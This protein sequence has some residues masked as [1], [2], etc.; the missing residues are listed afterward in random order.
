MYNNIE[1]YLGFS[2]RPSMGEVQ[3]PISLAVEMINKLPEEVFISNKTTFLDPCFGSGT[4]LK[5]I[6]KKLREYGH[7]DE[8]I[9]SRLFGVEKS[10]RFINIVGKVGNIKPTLIHANFLEYNFKNMKFDVIIGNPPY[11]D[12]SSRQDEGARTKGGRDMAKEFFE[13]SIELSK[14]NGY[15]TLMGPYAKLGR[16]KMMSFMSSKGLYKITECKEFF[17]N[18]IAYKGSIGVFYFNTSQINPELD[19]QI[20]CN[21]EIPRNNLSLLF[22]G[23][24]KNKFNNRKLIEPQLKDK[25]IY[26]VII[27]RKVTGYTDDINVVNQIND[28]S[29]G[30]W[31]VVLGYNG[32]SIPKIGRAIIAHPN[33][34]VGPSN[35]SLSVPSQDAAHVL[36]DYLK[37][38]ECLKLLVGTRR[39][40]TN[41]KRQFKYIP[42]PLV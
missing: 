28:T 42:N 3:T 12:H 37:S 21:F 30:S 11:N 23:A 16:K 41:S 8:N 18:T 27:T 14:F 7:S 17:K 10:I 38:E 19:N 13:K 2:G 1:K 9:N 24:K 29:R 15:V 31:R 26:K 33:D 40:I 32:D 6:T 39:A 34:I 5:V 22:N 35:I 4:F 25:G 36:V 20:E